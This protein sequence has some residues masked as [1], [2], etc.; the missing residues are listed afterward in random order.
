MQWIHQ[1]NIRPNLFETEAVAEATVVNIMCRVYNL[2]QFWKVFRKD[3][4]MQLISSLKLTWFTL[5]YLFAKV[6]M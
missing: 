4:K 6:K 1:V 2:T 5:K 3:R